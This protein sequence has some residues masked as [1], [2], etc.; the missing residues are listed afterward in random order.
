MEALTQA[1][2][3]FDA[4][5][6]P[7]E[8]ERARLELGVAMRRARQ[9]R[10]AR[11]TLDAAEA[12]FA[13]MGADGWAARAAQERE[14][15][16]GRA[17]SSGELTPIETQVADLVASGLP[18]KQVAAQL[19]LSPKTV[20]SHLS[21]IYAKTGVRSRTELAALLMRNPRRPSP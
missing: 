2:D 16:S 4:A 12:A 11:D 14:R 5:G 10:D 18:N 17:A 8:R 1:V 21:H 3:I 19:F 7:W 15:I 20:E 9:R 13:T 6:L